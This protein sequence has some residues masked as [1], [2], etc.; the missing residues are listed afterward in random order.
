MDSVSFLLDTIK[1]SAPI[2]DSN[3]ETKGK[4]LYSF[5]PK[6]YDDQGEPMNLMLLDSIDNLV[7][8]NMTI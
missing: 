3:G 5:E 8:R 1:D 6:V 2:F 7:G 4:L